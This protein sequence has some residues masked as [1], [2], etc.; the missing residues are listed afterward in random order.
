MTVIVISSDSTVRKRL[1]AGILSESTPIDSDKLF[2]I[3]N[4]SNDDDDIN[5]DCG[6]PVLVDVF[7]IH[8]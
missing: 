3:D 2:Q 4:V 8:W 5:H 6:P 1:S 7:I